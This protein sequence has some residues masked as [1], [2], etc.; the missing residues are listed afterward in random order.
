MAAKKSSGMTKI[1][2][3]LRA[4]SKDQKTAF[5]G[6]MVDGKYKSFTIQLKQEVEIPTVLVSNL[7]DA[8]VMGIGD[9]DVLEP[10]KRYIVTKA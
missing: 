2:V 7:E 6:G 9:S 4:P 8:Y 1:K 3:E 5:V 10:T